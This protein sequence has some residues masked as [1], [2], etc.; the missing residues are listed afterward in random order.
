[1]RY[2]IRVSRSPEKKAAAE[3]FEPAFEPL[4]RLSRIWRERVD[5]PARRAAVAIGFGSVLVAAHLAR[6]GSPWTRAAGAS[7]LLAVWA[8][9]LVR[10][11]ANRRAWR[12]PAK[13]VARTIV[14]T[15]PDLGQRTLRAMRLVARIDGDE[16]VGSR[17]L[18]HL[19]LERTLSRV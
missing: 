17:E 15:D 12:D 10:A 3:P 16:A 13:I 2:S 6:V 8:G 5:G 9:F 11:I 1:M 14:A 18:A 7:L 19:H 4:F